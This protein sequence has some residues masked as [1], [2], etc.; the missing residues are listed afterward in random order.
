MDN[1]YP[2]I[3][4]IYLYL[5][6]LIGLILMVIA[7]VQLADLGLKVYVFKQIEKQ[8]NYYQKTPPCGPL[9]EDRVVTAGEATSA[10]QLT[11]GEKEQMKM[12]L[13]DYKNW[14]EEQKSYDPVTA[15]R[16]RTASTA[17]SMLIVGLPLYFYHW[18][19]I[20]KETEENRA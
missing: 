16:Q 4:K 18:R 13:A 11:A 12:W 15:S 2:L 7:G 19:V 8:D 6:A 10:V 5:F 3:R 9:T 17:I 14:Q 1:K 20:K